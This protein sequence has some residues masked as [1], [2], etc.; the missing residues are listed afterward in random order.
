MRRKY[1]DCIRSDS[2]CA[3]CSLVSYGRDCHNNKIGQI[4]WR[5]KTAELTQ[6]ELSDRT[7]IDTRLLRKIE[8]GEVSIQNVTLSNAI[9]L[10]DALMIHDLRELVEG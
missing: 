4:E 10:A 7:G 1:T 3:K 2:N 8:T 9:K 6:V 5:R